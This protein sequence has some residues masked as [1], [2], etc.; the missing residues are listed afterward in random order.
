MFLFFQK[1]GALVLGWLREMGRM[2][3][4]LGE[5]VYWTFIPPLKF[6]R[7]IR[8]IGFIGAKSA[9]LIVL[10]GAF[11]GMILGLQVYYTLTKFGAEAYLGPAVALS[12]IRELGPV[13]AALMVTGRAGSALTAEIGIMR[14]TEQVDALESMS[15]SPYRYLVVPNLLA[16][17]VSFP[18]LAS[19]FNVVGIWGGYLIGVKLL[20]LSSGTYYSGIEGFVVLRDVTDGLIKSLCFGAI[21][22]WVSC[23]QGYYT[24]HGAEGVSRAT[25]T[26]VVM[27]STLILVWDYFL[28][29]VML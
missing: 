17:L 12:L 21:V 10:T 3:V 23:Y 9:P 7:V 4:F 1:I 6:G 20:G 29:S 15:L 5:T 14:I 8:Q 11:T 28:N 2:F 13:L 19:I 22:V 27:S 25:T 18:L 26:S 24:R 16:A